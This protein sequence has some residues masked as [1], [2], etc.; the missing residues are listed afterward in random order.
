MTLPFAVARVPWLCCQA[1]QQ[2]CDYVA[3]HDVDTVPH[4]FNV[5]YAFPE[6]KPR[7]LS[8]EMDRF[9]GSVPYL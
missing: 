6:R 3:L 9:N 2:G 1:L 8:Y 7:Q 5:S 4:L